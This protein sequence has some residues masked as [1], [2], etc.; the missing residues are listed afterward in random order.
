[1]KIFES[2]EDFVN[3]GYNKID[4]GKIVL[5]RQYGANSAVTTIKETKVRN[6]VLAALK[7]GQLSHED[8]KTIVNEFSADS[9]KWLNRNARYFSVSE[10]GV[11]LSSYGSK[12]LSHINESEEINEGAKFK[13]T[14]NFEDF[15]EEID[16]M[17]DSQIKKIMGK[18]YIDTPG[19]YSEEADDYN[20]D[21]IE[22]MT[23]NMGK[24]DF[25]KLK[26]YW[27]N[28]VAESL[29]NEAKS[30]L[31]SFDYNT[32]E[33]DVDYIQGLLKDAKVDAIAQPGLDSEEM[34]VKAKNEVELRK[35]KKAIQANG[36]EIYESVINEALKSSI[37]SS[38]IDM[39]YAP[40]DF[41]QYI[42]GYTKIALDQ[43]EDTDILSMD[44][45]RAYKRKAGRELVFYVVTNAKENPYA[46]TSAWSD[47]KNLKPDTILGVANGQNEFMGASWSGRGYTPDRKKMMAKADQGIGINKNY[48]GYGASGLYNV[49]RIAELAD[50]A[51]VIDIDALQARLSTGT[52]TNNRAEAK[53]GAVALLDPKKIKEENVNRYKAIIAKRLTEGDKTIDKMIE[54][55]I[56]DGTDLIKNA[57]KEKKMGQYGDIIAGTDPRGR[58]VKLSDVSS[59]LRNIMDDYARFTSAEENSKKD[60]YSG[61]YYERELKQYA[62]SIKERVAK[63]EKMDIAW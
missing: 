38:L 22:F 13:S 62:L 55:A 24:S 40:K 25:E 58:E 2:F 6:K 52:L 29:V 35:A 30:L 54:K 12:V 50:I 39:K 10:E 37:L 20:N 28:N 32:D 7:D 60:D 17:G 16:G 27:E 36:F 44:P 53:R 48:R 5:K 56:E 57:I 49:K 4:E 34:I 59:W 14:K 9:K 18:D 8:F 31:F 23:S 46:E 33:D 45:S 41:L 15:L 43:I 51:Y 19:F 42:Y 47:E 11:T 21:I 63:F 61:S 26:D 1:M 3:N